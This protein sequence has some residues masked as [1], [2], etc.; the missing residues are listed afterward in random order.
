M[1]S[2]TTD[3][4]VFVIKLFRSY[5]V[6]VVV[7]RDHLREFSV[8]VASLRDTIYWILEQFQETKMCVID[9]RRDLNVAHLI[10]R[11]MLSVQ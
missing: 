2:Y 6:L 10:V 11:K 9:V 4:K 3:Q 1:A 5:G 8:G 7:W